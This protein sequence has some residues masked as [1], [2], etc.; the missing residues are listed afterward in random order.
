VFAILGKPFTAARGRPRCRPTL[1]PL[2]ARNLPSFVPAVTYPLGPGPA[3]LAVGDF[4]GGGVPDLVSVNGNTVRVSPGNGDGTFQGP[5][6]TRGLPNG[7]HEGVAVGDFNG[8]DNLDLV[9]TTRSV[10]A[11]YPNFVSVL[12]GNGD[13]TFQAPVNYQLAMYPQQVAV[14]DLR[15]DGL[16]DLLVSSS[17]AAG[18]S[19][20]GTLVLLNNGDGT[21]TGTVTLPVTH[22]VVGDFLGDGHFDIAGV[23]GT[24]AV[25]VFPGTVCSATW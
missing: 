3:A 4:T 25:S 15:G 10:R 19:P 16:P 21:F 23:S 12:F 7:E 1:E 2:E 24:N 13:G 8:D 22:P 5:I 20:T 18:G 11:G 6:D 17:L 9:V 14:A